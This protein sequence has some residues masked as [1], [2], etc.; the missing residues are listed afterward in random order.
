MFISFLL[1][2]EALTLKTEN[3]PP[4]LILMGQMNRLD[5]LQ[6]SVSV[7]S[8]SKKKAKELGHYSMDI[9]HA[10]TN[11]RTNPAGDRQQTAR[12][13]SAISVDGPIWALD[14]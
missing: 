11:S 3:D 12:T 14:R 9:T 8:I 7:Y 4:I 1:K 6:L 10:R 13:A 2:G 5:S